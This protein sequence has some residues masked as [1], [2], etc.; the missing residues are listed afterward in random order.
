[1]KDT[2]E[3]HYGTCRIQCVWSLP[4]KG[5]IQGLYNTNPNHLM[6]PQ[7]HGSGMLRL[8]DIPSTV[9]TSDT[10]ALP[11]PTATSARMLLR[12]SHSPS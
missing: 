11:S 7:H 5:I 3:L 2:I 8:W 6:I 10:K 4:H 12:W 1:M 9:S